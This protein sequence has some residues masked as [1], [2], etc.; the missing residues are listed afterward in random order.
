MARV[1]V[2]MVVEVPT[3][4]ARAPAV[5]VTA[6][7]ATV[8]VA[9]TAA[10][11]RAVMARVSVAMAPCVGELAS[12]D[13]TLALRRSRASPRGPTPRHTPTCPP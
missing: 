12:S 5:E 2:A 6:V 7:R 11:V 1:S 3:V 8:T 13:H 9:M 4:R 10:E